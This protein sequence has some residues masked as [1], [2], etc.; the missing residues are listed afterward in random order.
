MSNPSG[1]D[2]LEAFRMDAAMLGGLGGAARPPSVAPRAGAVAAGIGSKSVHP[3]PDFEATLADKKRWDSVTACME[4]SMA[5]L[6]EIAGA[7]DAKDEDKKAARRALRAYEHTLELLT[8]GLEAKRKAEEQMI[9]DVEAR[10]KAAP[11]KKK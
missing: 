8:Q 3:Y 9:K 1:S 6:G 2:K 11:R 7:K 10:T 5:R 4:K